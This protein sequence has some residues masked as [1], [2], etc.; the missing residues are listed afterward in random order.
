MPE[1]RDDIHRWID[2]ALGHAEG[3]TIGEVLEL[4]AGQVRPPI[5]ALADATWPVFTSVLG[6]PHAQTW[7]DSL[8]DELLDEH[9]R[10][11]SS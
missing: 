6:S 11:A 7:V 9:E 1:M 4:S 8:V 2:Q 5:D 10:L 3:K